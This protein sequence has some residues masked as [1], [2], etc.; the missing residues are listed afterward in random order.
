MTRGVG[1]CDG[2]SVSERL[3]E[4]TKCAD[5]ISGS[6]LPF[7]VGRES[8]ELVHEEGAAEALSRTCGPPYARNVSAETRCTFTQ[9]PQDDRT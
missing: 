7:G 9:K 8:E 5:L 1:V 4:R 2:F 6:G 3:E